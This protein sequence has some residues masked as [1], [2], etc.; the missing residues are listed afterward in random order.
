M[1]FGLNE[2]Q[3][4][5]QDSVRRFLETAS[6]LEQVRG[7]AE[8]GGIFPSICAAAVPLQLASSRQVLDNKIGVTGRHELPFT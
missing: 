6:E 2:D 8:G 1:Y 7:F 3:T 4:M 5:L